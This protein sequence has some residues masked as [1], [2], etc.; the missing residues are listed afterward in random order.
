MVMYHGRIR[1]NITNE[2]NPSMWDDAPNKWQGV[3]KCL[4]N[5]L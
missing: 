5:G 2:R 1:K 3:F 4:V